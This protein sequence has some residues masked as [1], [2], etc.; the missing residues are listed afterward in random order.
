MRWPWKRETREADYTDVLIA[1]M[2]ALA[3]GEVPVGVPAARE[4]AAG[5]W[6]R[7][8]ASAELPPGPI[9]D[10]VQPHLGYVGRNLVT[11]GEAIFYLDTTGGRFQLLP[12]CSCNITG[13]PAP[14][15]WEYEVTL[16]G[17]SA[18]VTRHV[19]ADRILHLVYARSGQN[20]WK[21]IGP[22]EASSTTRTL[23]EN[24]ESRL[25]QEAGGAVGQL[26]PVPNVKTSGQLQADLRKMKGQ[27]TLVESMAA[28]WGAGQGT[29]PTGDYRTVR[30]GA[31]PPQPIIQLR[32]EAEESILAACG[33]S[34]ALLSHSDGTLLR[35]AF[36]QF[37]FGVVGPVSIQVGQQI[38]ERF[39]IPEFPFKFDRLAAA[40]VT[41][42]AR[43]VGSLVQAG[44]TL[45]K[46]LELTGF[47]E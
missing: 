12:A 29:A 2:L 19:G 11:A 3:S 37:V 33:L 25:A 43:A 44:V 42:R 47:E 18:T 13:D 8:F 41:G 46:A 28:A 38:A 27:V 20:P 30:V 14:E 31:N 32:R 5:Q 1:N 26:V 16:A 17:P 35:E 22:I 15:T 36:R 24:L 10:A 34:P 23:L 4:I 39:D 40:D 21:G 7:A 45:D 9:G 6:Q